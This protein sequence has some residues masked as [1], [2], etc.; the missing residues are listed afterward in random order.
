MPD[1]VPVLEARPPWAPTIIRTCLGVQPGERVLIAVDEP[2]AFVRDA[3]L[4]EARALQPAEL[5]SVTIPAAT[6]PFRSLP[7]HFMAR[8]MEADVVLLLLAALDPVHELPAHLAGRARIGEGP[9]RYAVGAYITE[10]I[11]VDE[12]SADYEE[13]S[14][15]TLA[16]AARLAGVSSVQLTSPLGTDLRLSTAGRA[17]YTDTGLLRGPGSYG[18][19][20]AGEVY[21]APV[22]ESAEGVVVIDQS[23]PGLV[24]PAPVRLSFEQ[25][26]VVRIEGEPGKTYLEEAIRDAEGKPN[27]KWARSLAEF[28]IGT[29]PVARLQGN[30]LTDEKAAGT[31]HVAIG[32]NDLF[33]GQSPAPLHVDGVV[34]TPTMWADG[35]LVIESGIPVM[36]T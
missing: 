17:W 21:I 28:G 1:G 18:N 5:W 25:G 33:G 20:P 13:I 19:L 27:G 4:A 12:L 8:A 7:E 36:R 32:R 6:R 23:L 10:D 34:G 26:R 35:E 29:N 11:L 9:A 2:L 15:Q 3:L 22:E 16:L 14:A 24:L 31:V 30:I